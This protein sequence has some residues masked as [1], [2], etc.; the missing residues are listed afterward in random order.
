MP[1]G[2][3]VVASTRPEN[4]DIFIDRP[5]GLRNVWHGV[6][7]TR[8]FLGDAVDH[9]VAVGKREVRVRC[10]PSTSV[11]PSTEVYLRLDP[12]KTLVAT[13]T[14][15]RVVGRSQRLGRRLSVATVCYGLAIVMLGHAGW[16]F[17]TIAV[18]GLAGACDAMATT[19]RHSIVQLGIPDQLRGRVTSLYQMS[20]RRGPA[21]GDTL[22]GALAGVIGPVAALT[23]D[24]LARHNAR[25]LPSLPTEPVALLRRSEPGASPCLTTGTPTSTTTTVKA[26]VMVTTTSMATAT[27]GRPSPCRPTPSRWTAS[28]ASRSTPPA[29][30]SARRHPT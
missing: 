6:V 15:F 8:A 9:I 2:T 24:G 3:E 11:D 22:I 28:S 7:T 16:V 20:S 18:A 4:V 1:A 19:I 5:A 21:L 14:V 12:S 23:A 13:Y 26:T 29:S 30:T 25:R 17:L 10:T 27:P